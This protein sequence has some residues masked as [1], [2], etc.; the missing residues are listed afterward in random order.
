MR[1]I[2]PSLWESGW[3]SCST[4]SSNAWSNVCLKE[5][6]V[7]NSVPLVFNSGSQYM[8]IRWNAL[9]NF[10]KNRWM[11]HCWCCYNYL[12]LVLLLLCTIYWNLASWS[13]FVSTD[14]KYLANAVVGCA[15]NWTGG[16]LTRYLITSLSGKWGAGALTFAKFCVI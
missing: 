12:L 9:K 1:A 11:C 4:L 10:V 2:S 13:L 8:V 7:Q 3:G 16:T 15:S 6:W 5:T 14:A